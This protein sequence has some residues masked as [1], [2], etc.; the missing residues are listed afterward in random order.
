LP[1]R[2]KVVLNVI[3]GG[4]AVKLDAVPFTP[5]AVGVIVVL[6]PPTPRIWI[7]AASWPWG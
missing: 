6:P 5:I 3:T 4:Y 7:S 2:K 1:R